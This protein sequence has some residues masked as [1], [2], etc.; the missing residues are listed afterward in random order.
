[1]ADLNQYSQNKPIKES[2]M[3]RVIRALISM[4]DYH[5]KDIDAAETIRYY[6]ETT[7]YILRYA[8][9][10]KSRFVLEKAQALPTLLAIDFMNKKSEKLAFL[11]FF[12]R[13]RNPV[14]DNDV[15]RRK[16]DQIS[17]DCSTILAVIESPELEK[18]YYQTK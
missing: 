2:S 3:T 16:L 7:D 8:E 18:M 1:M 6:K 12:S 4:L 15:L 9:Q 11:E 13:N 14:L 17:S 10:T 5:N